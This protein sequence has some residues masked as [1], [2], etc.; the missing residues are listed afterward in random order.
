MLDCDN[1]AKITH[2]ELSIW[3]MKHG[4]VMTVEDIKRGIS[5]SDKNRDGVIDR[6]EFVQIVTKK[7]LLTQL[8]ENDYA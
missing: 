1:T 4:K 3:M 8:R 7:I 6:D 5:S 2:Q